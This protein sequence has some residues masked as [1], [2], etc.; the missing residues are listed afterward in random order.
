MGAGEGGYQMLRGTGT[1]LNAAAVLLGAGVGATLGDR[2]P[3]RIR[4]V[5][6]DALGLTTVLIA[7]LDA[8]RVNSPTLARSVGG[9]APVLVVLGALAIGGG[10]GAALRLEERVEQLGGWVRRR[11]SHGGGD[12]ESR[13]RFVDGFVL[14]SLLFCVG[15]LTILGSFQ[16]G[17]GRGISLLAVKSALD[18]LA[19]VAFAAS[20][21]P[22][23]A[24]AAL[25][26]LVVQGS[27]TALGA[28]AG[29]V[30]TAAQLVALTATG[31]LLLAGVAIRLLRL[32]EVAV[33]DLLPALVVAPLL[34]SVAARLHGG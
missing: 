24:V 26:V 30:L 28:V 32:R 11:L 20:Y 12:D 29:S 5:V 21:G 34:A 2:L 25:T 1:L 23:V 27:L 8:A 31:G 19:S 33:A 9:S 18:G 6:T 10:V 3:E 14:A 17:L 4:E 15:P 16:D 13:R 7:A 22:G